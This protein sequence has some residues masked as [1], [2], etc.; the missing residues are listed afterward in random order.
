MWWV[1]WFRGMSHACPVRTLRRS[2]F[3]THRIL[4]WGF[5]FEASSC[6]SEMASVNDANSI[7]PTYLGPASMPYTYSHLHGLESSSFLA[8][9]LR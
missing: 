1:P 5:I 6:A 4:G 7:G 9:F 3:Q 8:S 2:G